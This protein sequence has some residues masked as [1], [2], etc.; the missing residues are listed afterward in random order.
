VLDPEASL[1]QALAAR[2]V[3]LRSATVVRHVSIPDYRALVVDCEGRRGCFDVF[4][5]VD[6]RTED[7]A[8][9]VD[10]H[11]DACAG[12]PANRAAMAAGDQARAVGGRD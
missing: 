5:A 12:A 2:H 8:G 1:R 6:L 10:R 9:W 7:W 11:C 4:S 3:T